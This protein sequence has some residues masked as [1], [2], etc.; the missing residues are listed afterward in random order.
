MGLLKNL[1]DAQEG[2]GGGPGLVSG[3][4]QMKEQAEQLGQWVASISL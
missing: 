1:M 4:M 2:C 3:A